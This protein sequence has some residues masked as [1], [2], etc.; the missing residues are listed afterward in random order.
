MSLAAIS[1]NS[2]VEET[3]EVKPSKMVERSLNGGVVL[4][5]VG[6]P[7][8]LLVWKWKEK[9]PT[10]WHPVLWGITLHCLSSI[11][12]HQGMNW[13]LLNCQLSSD[14]L[15]ASVDQISCSF[16]AHK[17]EILCVEQPCLSIWIHLSA[18]KKKRHF[19][20]SG[21]FNCESLNGFSTGT[22]SYSM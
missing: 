22:Y 14:N 11:S 2:E 15:G 8:L 5:S 1:S 18:V 10:W 17:V 4:P 19:S 13:N 16:C 21:C 9:T 12:S 20:F 7:R 6:K 3:F